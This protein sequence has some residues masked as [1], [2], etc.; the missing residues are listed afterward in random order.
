M[1]N[2]IEFLDIFL[3]EISSKEAKSEPCL[4]EKRRRF[5]HPHHGFRQMSPLSPLLLHRLLSTLQDLVDA[6]R[7]RG[8]RQREAAGCCQSVG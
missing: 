4:R 8:E 7:G 1:C 2:S 5:P 3:R 6:R